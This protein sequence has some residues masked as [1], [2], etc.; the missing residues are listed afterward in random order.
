[1]NAIAEKLGPSVTDMIRADHSRVLATFHRYSPDAS[2]R[3][4]RGLVD[5]ICLALEVHSQ[6]EEEIFYPAL[7][8]IDPDIVAKS[9]P[10]HGEVKRLVLALRGMSPAEAAF[11]ATVMELMRKVI[12]H[13]A[14]EE[15]TL[16]PDAE[17]ELAA[18]LPELGLRMAKRRLELKAPRAG[19]MAGAMARA[20][21]G[22]GMLIGAGAALVGGALLA[23]ALRHR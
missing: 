11:D 5:A 22:K 4:K 9:L 15:T 12:H 3:E 13:V 17:R 10:E 1:M 7:Q 19:E 16:L 6:V 18:E 21:S 14:D 20:M 8:R 23:R 2:Q